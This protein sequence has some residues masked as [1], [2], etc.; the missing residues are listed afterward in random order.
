[1]D[2]PKTL[3]RGSGLAFALLALVASNSAAQAADTRPLRP[4]TPRRRCSTIPLGFAGWDNGFFIRS[5]DGAFILK[6]AATRTLDGRFFPEE[7]QDLND[8]GNRSEENKDQFV[9]R[10]HAR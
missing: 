9:L 8:D 1:V 6:C 4:P 5:P 10:A 2:L 7:D 3:R